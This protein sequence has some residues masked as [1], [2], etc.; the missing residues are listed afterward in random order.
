[1]WQQK[2]NSLYRKFEFQSFLEAVEFVDKVASLAE[3]H[4]HHPK[5]I[6]DYNVVELWA[7]TH[8]ANAVTEKDRDLANAIDA[9]LAKSDASVDTIGRAKLF[10]DGGSRG[11]PGPSA[12][13]FVILDM[14][15]IV[16][17]KGSKYLGVTTNN[18]AEYLGLEEG[19]KAC[20][21]GGVSNL[22]VYMDS[23]LIVNQVKGIYKVKTAELAPVHARIKKLETGFESISFTHVPRAMNSIADGLVNECLD[24]NS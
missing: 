4:N 11:N 19:M 1:M 18:Q 8:S 2:N 14:E 17:K 10:T 16:V 22:E 12:L 15:D 6:L 13:G 20:L 5:I 7:T 21:D 9:L 3:E 23:L 24:K